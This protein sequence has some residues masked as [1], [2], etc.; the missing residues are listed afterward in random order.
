MV[1]LLEVR[2]FLIPQSIMNKLEWFK[3]SPS[4][5][6]MGR[7][8]RVPVSVQ[9][10]FIRL[11]CVYWNRGCSMT[12]AEVRMELSPNGYKRLSLTNVLKQDGVQTRILFLDAQM[13]DID[14]M[15]ELASKAGRASAEARKR[16]ASST[17]VQRNPTDIDK[18]KEK[19]L[20]DTDIYREFEHLKITVGEFKKLNQEYSEDTIEHILDSIENYKHKEHYK[21]LYLT[22]RTW[23]KDK[24]KKVNN[25]VS[26]Q[27][28][29]KDVYA[30]NVMKKLGK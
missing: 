20:I 27:E 7:I 11:C 24:P 18:E 9:G 8:S 21:S 17:P 3:F 13:Q 16:K 19:E 4:D 2:G 29:I 1:A 26:D 15:R 22:A 28:Q 6:T 25:V 14:N 30:E 5:W 12:E 10:E 23:L